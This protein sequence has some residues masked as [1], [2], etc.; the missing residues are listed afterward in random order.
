MS[1]GF[2]IVGVVVGVALVA[3]IALGALIFTQPAAAAALGV[4]SANVANFGG[5]GAAG[6]GQAGLAAAAKALNM[7]TTDLQ[8]QLRGGATLSSLASKA[9]VKLADVLAAVDAACK[10]QLTNAINAAVTAG[11]LTRD[12]AD[13]LIQ[14]LDKGYWGPGATGNGNFGFGGFGG[15]GGFGGGRGFGFRF[16]PGRGNRNNPNNPQATPQASASATANS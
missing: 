5:G 4:N 11:T 15:P 9:N 8:T 3:A 12:K 1:K 13:W 7:S 2:K 10:T 16:G 6:C 14:G